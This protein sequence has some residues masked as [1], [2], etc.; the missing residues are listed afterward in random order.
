M[1]ARN[2]APK[3]DIWARETTAVEK[4]SA[5]AQTLIAGKRPELAINT[6]ASH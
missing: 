5:L 4:H 2:T 6:R 3:Q 1:L